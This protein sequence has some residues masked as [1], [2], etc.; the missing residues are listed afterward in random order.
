VTDVSGWGDASGHFTLWNGVAKTLSYA[1]PH[2]DP[3]NDLYYFWLTSMEEREDGTKF[4]VQVISV[5]FWE[6]K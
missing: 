5:K 2:D 1:E 6:L 3:E 4:L